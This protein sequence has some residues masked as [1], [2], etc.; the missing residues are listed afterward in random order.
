MKD[1]IDASALYEL[2]P[3][4]KSLVVSVARAYREAKE[5]PAIAAINYDPNPTTQS[6]KW[7]PE[8]C[9]FTLDVENAVFHA[10]RNSS[11]KRELRAT[12]E[13][14]QDESNM[15]KR[16]ARSLIRLLAPIFAARGLSPERYFQR[17]RYGSAKRRPV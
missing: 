13:H 3:S 4:N 8:S 14:L 9:H 15:A 5:L 17:I 16:D 12:W 1:E 11:Y 2:R 10:L 7:T 6:R